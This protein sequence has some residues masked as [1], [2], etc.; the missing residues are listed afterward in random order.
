MSTRT[1]TA[2][3]SGAVIFGLDAPAALV[4]VTVSA[5]ADVASVELSGPAEVVDGA[6]VSAI[7]VRWSLRLPSTAA[8]AATTVIRSAGGVTVINSTIG[9]SVIV[10]DSMT[11]VNGQLVGGTNIRCPGVEPVR[12]SV[13]LPIRSCLEARVDAGSLVTRGPLP[14]VSVTGTSADVQI[15]SAGAAEVRTVSG[16][17]TVSAVADC[18]RLRTIS[19]DIDVDAAAGQV[20]AQTTSGDITVHAESF[21]PVDA[22]SV[23]GDIR[24]TA[25]PGAC[26]DVRARS[27]SGRVRT[28][29]GTR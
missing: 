3:G 23:S 6:G 26:P 11:F 28:T 25:G 19:G 14:R 7:G 16:D 5:D 21:G 15:A 12:L 17:I 13:T 24:V 18:A 10:G 20:S 27:V 4:E 2:P 22:A 29:G 1:F 9:A 8:T